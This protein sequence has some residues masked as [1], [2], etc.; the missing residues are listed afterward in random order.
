MA[1]RFLDVGCGS[2][3]WWLQ[4]LATLGFRYLDGIDPF[5]QQDEVLGDIHYRRTTLERVDGTYDF[6]TLHHSLEH[7]PDQLATLKSIVARLSADGI[8]MVRIPVFPNELWEQ[9]GEYWFALDAPRHLYLHSVNSISLL[10]KSAGLK[11]VRH[12]F[13]M[14][15]FMFIA[16]E[17][18]RL[19][20]SLNDP[21]SYHVDRAQCPFDASQIAAWR[22]RAMELNAEGRADQAT[23]VFTR[24]AG[25]APGFPAEHD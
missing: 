5:I 19:G 13:D 7:I 24:A 3:S 12:F 20:I 14:T 8:A 4:N 18:Y 15:E 17:Q 11:L 25:T 22:K 10:A 23:F 16:S 6:L 2:R 21:H 9:Y 1:T